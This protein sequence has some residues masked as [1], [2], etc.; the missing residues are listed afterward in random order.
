MSGASGG[1]VCVGRVHSVRHRAGGAEHDG[2]HEHRHQ[3]RRPEQE[4]VQLDGEGADRLRSPDLRHVDGRE[5]GRSRRLLPR[6]RSA[7]LVSFYL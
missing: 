3:A 5:D 6:S 7:E 4:G 1:G 2:E